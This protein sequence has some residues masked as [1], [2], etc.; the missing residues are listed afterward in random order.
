[1]DLTE[2]PITA[3]AGDP[4]QPDE[5]E[6]FASP[7]DLCRA[8]ALLSVKGDTP[9]LEPL[10]D[11]L[12]LNPGVPGPDGVWSRIYFKGGGEPGLVAAAWLVEAPDGRRFALTG[13]VV[14]PD[15][16]IDPHQAILLLAAARDFLATS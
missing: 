9:G 11:V 3:F 1:M 14:D 16:P 6:W 15:A 4:L 12:T 7:M 13:S 5:I 8:I 10:T 2:I